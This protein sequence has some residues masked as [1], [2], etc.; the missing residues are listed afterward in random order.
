ASHGLPC[1]DGKRANFD[2]DTAAE[3]VDHIGGA[4]CAHRDAW[5]AAPVTG[6]D[7]CGFAPAVTVLIEPLQVELICLFCATAI[8]QGHAAGWVVGHVE[9]PAADQIASAIE[10]RLRFTPCGGISNRP[11]APHQG[12]CSVEANLSVIDRPD[13][14]Q[15]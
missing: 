13:S 14:D 11:L 8:D 5:I 4:V 9:K 1:R 10:N 6:C 12:G 3:V 15:P 7:H 2:R